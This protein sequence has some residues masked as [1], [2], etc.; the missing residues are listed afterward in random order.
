M[1]A[2]FSLPGL[3][4][5]LLAITILSTNLLVRFERKDSCFARYIFWMLIILGCTSGQ[6]FA[7]KKPAEVIDKKVTEKGGLQSTPLPLYIF[8]EDDAPPFLRNDTMFAYVRICKSLRVLR[9]VGLEAK[10]AGLTLE[11][12]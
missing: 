2:F 9:V 7:Q 11:K 4:T 3:T 12:P 6:A 1:P 5:V 10:N 8:E